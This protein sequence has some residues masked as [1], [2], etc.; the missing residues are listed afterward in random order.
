MFNLKE[1]KIIKILKNDGVGVMPTDTLY[2]LVG[3]AFSKKAVNRIY[4]LKKRNKKKALIILISNLN[5]LKKFGIVL[6]LLRGSAPTQVG[7]RGSD[8]F[9]KNW[10]GKVSIIL[11][12]S[13][14]KFKYIHQGLNSIAFRLPKNKKLI[15]ILKKTGPLVA[16]SANLEGER[17]VENIKEA[18]EYFGDKVDPVRNR[19]RAYST[20]LK[21]RGAAI[22]N[23]V[24]FYLAGGNLKGNPSKLIKINK[25][26]E[27][28]ILR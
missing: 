13:N 1:K 10:P 26:G 15:E 6:P 9:K 22:S 4:K 16:P 5:D 18:K 2:G 19:A 25:K 14:N 8:I 17:P 28:E 20:S 7:A 24:D 27:I 3:S 23:G 11:P 12:C 21:D